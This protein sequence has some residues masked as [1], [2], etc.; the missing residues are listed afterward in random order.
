MVEF[1]L[2]SSS[3]RKP[4]IILYGDDGFSRISL[5]IFSAL[6]PAPR[7]KSFVLLFLLI[8]FDFFVSQKNN[9]NKI[10]QLLSLK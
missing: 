10:E 9:L 8:L 1:D 2:E 7:S 6:Q 3:S 5:T 4:V